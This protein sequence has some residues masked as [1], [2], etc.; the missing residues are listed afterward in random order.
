[1]NSYFTFFCLFSCIFYAS[2]LRFG[3]RNY[4][5]SNS[6]QNENTIVNASTI[7]VNSPSNGGYPSFIPASGNNTNGMTLNDFC[8]YVAANGSLPWTMPSSYD[9]SSLFSNNLNQQSAFPPMMVISRFC[10]R[11]AANNG[12]FVPNRR[13]SKNNNR[14]YR[15]DTDSKRKGDRTP[16]F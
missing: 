16:G 5:N 11:L 2:A 8:K 4:G 10:S 14:R 15:R 9:P 6:N 3:N 1:M 12:L 13:T 7:W